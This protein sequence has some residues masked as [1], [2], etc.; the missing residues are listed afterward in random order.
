MM[1]ATSAPIASSRTNAVHS[2]IPMPSA[3]ALLPSR[4][5]T[6]AVAKIRWPALVLMLSTTFC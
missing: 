5:L 4:E 2:Q 3:N 6:K 1:K